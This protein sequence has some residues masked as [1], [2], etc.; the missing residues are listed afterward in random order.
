MS[1]N[2]SMNGDEIEW[3]SWGADAF[4]EAA[5]KDLPIILDIGAVWCHWCHVM[6]TGIPG[7]ALH[8]GTYSNRDVQQRINNNFIP[9]K[10]DN[11][12]RPDV[13]A[14]YNMGGWPTTAFLTP[15]GEIIYGETYVTPD[16]MVGLLDHI[17]KIWK[18]QKQQIVQK[19]S[20]S[21]ISK[22]SRSDET[23]ERSEISPDII[24]TVVTAIKHQFDSMFGGFGT[25]PKFPHPAA[26][27]FALDEFQR[28]ND[29]E[30]ANIVSKT[31]SAMAQGGMYDQ[32]AGGFFRYSTTRDWSVPHYEK[33]LED[34]ARLIPVYCSAAALLND[35]KYLD[36]VRSVE[37]WLFSD[38]LDP[39][40]GA[41]SGS[42]DADQE[43]IYYGE[44]LSV[45]ATMPT[46]YIDRTI[47]A[48][49]NCLV[50]SALTAHYKV[51]SE[52]KLLAAAVRCFEHV[53][54]NLSTRLSDGSVMVTHYISI[55][56]PGC[57]GLLTE[58]TSFADAAL[59]LYEVS[60]DND[61]LDSAIASAR[62]MITELWPDHSKPFQ[63]CPAD[64]NALGALSKPH[65]DMSEN[66]NAILMLIRL[67]TL[68]HDSQ[69]SAAAKHISAMYSEQ[70]SSQSYFASQYARATRLLLSPPLHVVIAGDE[71]SENAL[72]ARNLVW[73]LCLPGVVAVF[74]H[75]AVGGTA[76][77]PVLA[78]SEFAAY[79]CTGD[80][81]LAP[82]TDRTELLAQ[83]RIA[84]S[85]R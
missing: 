47:Y 12:K 72:S 38:M 73:S 36:T 6:D 74:A 21:Q 26:L 60:G 23:H 48:N 19:L 82:V 33:M 18:T 69:Y 35:Q 8:T 66:A 84:G 31:L 7:D 32:F 15:T 62:Y 65:S 45:R 78:G 55:D 5:V 40:S 76:A 42:M 57:G 79:I 58:Q 49:W 11:D 43:E 63:D 28:T 53:R 51:D 41:F 75:Q 9:I 64:P 44:P 24:Q 13:N 50:V 14:R 59:D 30:L 85:T 27:Q 46:P 17:A 81:C 52:P 39:N 37:Q 80:R 68:T 70:V 16:R 56:E 29:S 10:V 2:D 54:R 20:E 61:Y 67:H 71:T 1:N 25:Q 22:D 77:Y 83:L 34:N 4:D 3:R